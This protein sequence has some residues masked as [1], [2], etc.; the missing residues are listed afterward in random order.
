M[1]QISRH[2]VAF[3]SGV[4]ESLD[5]SHFARHFLLSLLPFSILVC[6][7]INNVW[8]VVS[9]SNP[10]SGLSGASPANVNLETSFNIN[11]LIID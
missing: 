11:I 2:G 10:G 3:V 4:R 1:L 6:L 8:H 5:L 7:L 9:T